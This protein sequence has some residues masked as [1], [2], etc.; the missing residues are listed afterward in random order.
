[1]LNEHNHED[2]GNNSFGGFSDAGIAFLDISR[3]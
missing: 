1:M 2:S 3:N